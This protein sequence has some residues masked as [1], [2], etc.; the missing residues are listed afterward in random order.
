MKG[1]I[2]YKAGYNRVNPKYIDG[3][4]AAVN[5]LKVG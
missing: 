1:I 5:Y 3:P 4:V 2:I